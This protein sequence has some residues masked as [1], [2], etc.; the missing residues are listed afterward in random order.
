VET[1]RQD[2]ISEAARA[3][4][5]GLGLRGHV[6]IQFKRDRRSQML[7]IM[8]MHTRN[9]L[10][11]YLATGSGLNITAIAYYDMIG[12]PCPFPNGVRY[13]VKWIDLNKDIK[14][15]A[16]YRKTGEWTV[17]RWWRSYTGR[18]VFHVH[19]LRDPKPLLMD[20]WFLMKRSLAQ[21]NGRG[22][23]PHA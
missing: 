1:V 22:A 5:Q 14:S 21:R 12:R 9:S 20:T 18:K 7:K 3:A 13:G 10:W 4:A 8:E 2:E 11:A 23:A 16:D 6:N 19:S 15:L 17:S